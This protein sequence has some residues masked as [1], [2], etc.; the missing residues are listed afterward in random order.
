M[1]ALKIYSTFDIYSWVLCIDQLRQCVCYKLTSDHSYL[2]ATLD[3][4]DQSYRHLKCLGHEV[5]IAQLVR[6]LG[7]LHLNCRLF[8]FVSSGVQVINIEKICTG[9]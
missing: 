2:Q 9:L 5:F 8:H 4:N 3:F 6:Q 7:I 1:F